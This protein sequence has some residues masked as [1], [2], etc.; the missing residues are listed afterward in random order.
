MKVWW[1]RS[2]SEQSRSLSIEKGKKENMK[3][4]RE[5]KAKEVLNRIIL[6]PKIALEKKERKKESP[7]GAPHK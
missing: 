3:K 2:P 1:N 5:E 7:Y 4:R 6:K